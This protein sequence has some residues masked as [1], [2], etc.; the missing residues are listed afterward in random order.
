MLPPGTRR[1]KWRRTDSSFE[2]DLDEVL[3]RLEEVPGYAPYQVQDVMRRLL[4][5]R[6]ASAERYTT[7]MRLNEQLM[8][9]VE[10]GDVAGVEARL[11]SGAEAT[12]VGLDG[13]TTLHLAVLMSSSLQLVRLLIANGADEVVDVRTLIDMEP[14]G[15]TA[16]L[17]AITNRLYDIARALLDADADPNVPS[18]WNGNELLPLHA[19]INVRSPRLVQLL[20]VKGADPHLAT[21]SRPSAHAYARL[22][23]IAQP[24]DTRMQKIVRLLRHV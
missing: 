19:A 3:Y 24:L 11:E 2:R 18:V 7:L 13:R 6:G 9:D 5:A 22:Q 16:L 14:R 21:H 17:I 4:R 15:F 20:L 12:H 1:T 10:N 23:L 8:R